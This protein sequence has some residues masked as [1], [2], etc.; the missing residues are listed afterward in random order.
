MN[1][2]RYQELIGIKKD[3]RTW[4]TCNTC[5]VMWQTNCLTEST[6]KDIY[7]HYRDTVFR[8][9]SIAEIFAKVDSLPPQESE[10]QYRYR[11]FSSH[12]DVPGSILDVGSGFGIWPSILKQ[13]YWEVTCIEPNPDSAKFI[14]EELK[15]PCYNGFD[16]DGITGRFDVVSVIHVLEHIMRPERFLNLVKSALRPKGRVFIEVPDSTEFNSLPGDHDEFNSTHLYF[17]DVPSLYRLLKQF[18]NVTDIHRV[19]YESRGLHRILALCR[20][21]E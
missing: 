19:H 4:Y 10:N 8:G 14:R 18:F 17:Y 7:S 13:F 15:I 21:T 6:L 11:W 9:L 20:N 12:L 16:L 5:G 1:P 2:D 3:V